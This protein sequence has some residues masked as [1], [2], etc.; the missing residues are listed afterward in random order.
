MTDSSDQTQDLSGQA[1]L[2]R[3]IDKVKDLSR[4]I[5]GNGKEGLEHEVTVMSTE[6]RGM[7]SDID[8]IKKGVYTI[9]IAL[10]IS[11]ICGTVTFFITGVPS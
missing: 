11:G 6:F 10:V 8:T 3:L 2:L 5:N 4:I 7:K 9:I 1:L